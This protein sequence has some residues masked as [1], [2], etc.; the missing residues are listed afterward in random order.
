MELA[1]WIYSRAEQY[2]AGNNRN[3]VQQAEHDRYNFELTPAQRTRIQFLDWQK[4]NKEKRL[5]GLKAWRDFRASQLEG[6]NIL[7]ERYGIRWPIRPFPDW[8]D[9]YIK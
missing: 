5:R 1:E 4:R 7:F 6:F 8:L 2:R 9:R 3:P